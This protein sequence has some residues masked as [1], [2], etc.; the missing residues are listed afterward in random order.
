VQQEISASE[1]TGK[2]L[3]LHPVLAS[4]IAAD[5]RIRQASS[6]DSGSGVLKVPP[7]SISVFVAR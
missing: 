2:S 3:S 7:R 5:Q 4:D 6:F 1:L